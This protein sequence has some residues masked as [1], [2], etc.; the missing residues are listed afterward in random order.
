MKSSRSPI[1]RQVKL[2]AS[3]SSRSSRIISPSIRSS[4]LRVL[5]FNPTIKPKVKPPVPAA[6]TALSS[7]AKWALIALIL[8][9]VLHYWYYLILDVQHYFGF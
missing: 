9:F 4:S 5:P 2:P 8:Y 6:T 1:H 7:R 3:S